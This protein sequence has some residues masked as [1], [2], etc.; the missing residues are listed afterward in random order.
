MKI[1]SANNTKYNQ[2]VWLNHEDSPSTGNVV[3]YDGY[4]TNWKGEQERETFISISDCYNSARLHMN[5]DDSIWDFVDKLELLRD[6]I[7]EFITH[8]KDSEDGTY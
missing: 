5:R 6:T 3:T 7:D 4:V 8:L 2:R 1:L